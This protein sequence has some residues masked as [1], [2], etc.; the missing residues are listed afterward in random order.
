MK[1]Y[2]L[3]PILLAVVLLLTAYNSFG[4]CKRV[5]LIGEFTGWA[6][7][8]FMDRDPENP[9][10]FTAML[11]LTDADDTS[12]PADGIVELKFREDADWVVNWG[13]AA[14]PSGTA[15]ANGPNIPVPV[16]AYLVTFN[17]ATGDYNFLATCGTV[18]MIGEFNGW[19][20][21]YALARGAADPDEWSGFITLT[22]D[23]DTNTDGIVE[24]KFRENADW[25][26]N[27]GDAAFPTG[28]ATQDGPNIPVPLGTYKVTFNCATGG[29]AFYPTCGSISLIGEF[30]GWSDDFALTRDPDND[31]MWHAIFQLEES[32]D[33]NDPPDGIVELKFRENADWAVNWGDAAFPS[34]TAVQD[35][36]NIPVPLGGVGIFTTYSVS[37]NCGTG[38][39]TFQSTC[40]SVSMIGAFNNWNGDVPM[41]RDAAD[42]DEWTLTRSWFADSEVKF[43]ENNDWSVNWGNSA[44]PSG[45]GTSNGPNIPL[46]AGIYDVTFNCATFD[47]SFTTNND[48][49][50]EIGI[51]GDFNTWGDDGSAIPTDVNLIRD[52]NYPSQFSLTY[53]FTSGT[54]LLFREDA[55]VAFLNVWGGT[56]PTG[57]GIQDAAALMDVPGGKYNITFNCKSGDYNFERLGNS[58]IAPKVFSLNVDG[59][60]SEKDWN[61]SQT[62]SNIVEGA[63]GADDNTVQYAVAYNDEYLY[64][65]VEV[66]D[67]EVATGGTPAESDAVHVFIDGNKSGGDY[68]A[69]D[70]YFIVDASGAVTVV[71]GTA[72]PE[73]A[74]GTTG[75]GYA[76]EARVAWADL[77]ITPVVGGQIGFDLG[78]TDRDAG[79]VQNFMMWNGGTGNLSATATF[80]DLLLGGLSCGDISIYNDFVGD[81]TLHTPTDFPTTFVGTYEFDANQD[82]VFRK[83][84]ESVVTWGDSDFPSGTA[85]LGGSVIPATTGRYRVSF[86]CL[87][88]TYSFNDETGVDIAYAQYTT[89][90][91]VMDGTLNEYSLDYG[92]DAGV[93]DGTGPNNNTVEWGALWDE[94]NLYIGAKV[95]DAVVEGSGNPWE[96]DAIEYY[97]DGNHDSDGPFDADWDTQL[98]MDFFNDDV[99]WAKADGVPITDAEGVFE[100]TATGYNVEIR[101]AWSNFRFAPGRNRTLG[102]TIGNNDSDNGLGRDYQTAWS[103]TANNWNDTG[104]H[105][106]LQLAGGPYT[107]V[108]EIYQNASIA[109]FPNPVSA[110]SSIFIATDGQTFNGDAVISVISMFGQE[111]TRQKVNFN[112]TT[113]VNVSTGNLIPGTYVIH[114][115]SADGKRAAVKK[116]MVH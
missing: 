71:N 81:V 2:L 32:D 37:F 83:D 35:G 7:D 73:G 22:E 14:F 63:S 91:V 94:N 61:F 103:G 18:S 106:D 89:D 36:S 65:G 67:A 110:N 101:I 16:G 29:Y 51:I 27:W 44:W 107:N 68:D 33:T 50:G 5:G 3:H 39:Y 77:G 102:F 49:C 114:V 8:L 52:P 60:T 56:Y 13:D 17:C 97:F 74:F 21:D 43:R 112:G 53:N 80:G 64:I 87:N 47:Y 59:E 95:T 82:V 69:N 88:G 34:G 9:E 54:K 93:V 100:S 85:T 116:L 70:V 11:I 86:D 108:N 96:N 113:L 12:V 31:L 75:S 109:V 41:N 78:V 48:V 55:D 19:A 10:M 45:T 42:P 99:L 46:V 6:G 66:T 24:L 15:V 76:V 30:N 58:V 111:V 84:F 79:A 72:A 20:N 26:V 92:M 4:Q 62:V 57:T 28:T 105:G 25:A 40:G 1:K 23:D 115:L 104:V 38:E 98:I 90:D